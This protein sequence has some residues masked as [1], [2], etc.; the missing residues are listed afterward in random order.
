[1]DA[2]KGSRRHFRNGVAFFFVLIWFENLQCLQATQPQV[3]ELGPEHTAD[4]SEIGVVSVVFGLPWPVVGEA[5]A[6]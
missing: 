4:A 5:P 1:M 6:F 2:L 3:A